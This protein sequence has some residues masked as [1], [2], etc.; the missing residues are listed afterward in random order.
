MSAD[1]SILVGKFKNQ[2]RVIH[3]AA[4]DNLNYNCE[5]YDGEYNYDEVY[6][7][8]KSAKRFYLEGPA[9]DYAHE[10]EEYWGYVEYGISQLDFDCTW[11]EVNDKRLFGDDEDDLDY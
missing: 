1:N 4:V 6:R 8:F 5:A 9:W 2:Y 10:L 3:A 7:Y 11:E